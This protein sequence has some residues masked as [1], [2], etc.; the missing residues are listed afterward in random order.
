MSP[1]SEPG[2]KGRATGRRTVPTSIRQASRYRGPSCLS[3]SVRGS[4]AVSV[5][6]GRS[7]FWRRSYKVGDIRRE[8]LGPHDDPVSYTH[9]RAHETR[10]DLVCRLLLEK[11]KT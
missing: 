11:K 8:R 2:A 10:H 9:L 4:N 6:P 7:A 3:C 5:A 1:V